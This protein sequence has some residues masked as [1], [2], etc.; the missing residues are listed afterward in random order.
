ML[1]RL[2]KSMGSKPE[3]T[4]VK[5]LLTHAKTL[6]QG[7]TTWRK[8]KKQAEKGGLADIDSYFRKD[9]SGLLD[10]HAKAYEQVAVLMRPDKADRDVKAIK[11][12]TDKLKAVISKLNTVLEIYTAILAGGLT[13]KTRAIAKQHIKGGGKAMPQDD[14]L[15]DAIGRLCSVI[16][17]DVKG[18]IG[19]ALQGLAPYV[20]GF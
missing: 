3:K 17:F 18:D 13:A 10:K 4:D 20:R 14:E 5:H 9:L 16:T 2:L 12:G 7:S 6:K 1:T 11:T 8:A 15:K 19:K